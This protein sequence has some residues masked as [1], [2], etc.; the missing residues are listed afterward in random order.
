MLLQPLLPCVFSLQDQ[1]Q[2]GE[3]GE[4]GPPGGPSEEE[5]VCEGRDPEEEG[6][7]EAGPV[8]EERSRL[9]LPAAGQPQQPLPDHG[10]QGGQ[11]V[12]AHRH[13]Q[14]G[15]VQQ[16]V[17]NGHQ[18]AEDTQVSHL[19]ER[20]Q[21][22]SRPSLYPAPCSHLIQHKNLHNL[23]RKKSPNVVF[24]FFIYISIYLCIFPRIL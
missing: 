15:Q 9:P 14:V 3:A 24:L 19:R 21:I 23:L 22:M 18:E 13:P 20:L 7:E 6:Y 1:D 2:G 11:T 5:E 17:Q 16:G 4:R 10:P 8:P 12:P